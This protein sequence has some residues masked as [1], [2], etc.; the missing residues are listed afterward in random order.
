MVFFSSG[1][2]GLDE[3]TIGYIY[4]LF[5]LAGKIGKEGCGVNPIAGLNNLQGGY[6]MGL[7]P[8]L[9]TGFQPL[10]DAATAKKFEKEWGTALPSSP[11]KPIYRSLADQASER[12]ALVGVDNDEGMV[13]VVVR[14]GS[15][16]GSSLLPDEQ[17]YIDAWRR[18]ARG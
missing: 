17:A 14:I 5:L 13:C 2:S 11:G 12:K 8:D 16:Y 9:L 10:A 1:I 18:R 4:N 15:S 6:D 7:A 3:D